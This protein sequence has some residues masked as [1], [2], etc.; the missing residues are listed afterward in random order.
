VVTDSQ[1]C[2]AMDL[3][4]I[5]SEDF[6]FQ[7]ARAL[8]DFK[9]LARKR[10][11]VLAK[12]HHPDCTDQHERVELFRAAAQIVSDIETTEYVPAPTVIRRKR[13]YSF[14]VTT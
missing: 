5:G 4:G 13:R 3:L 7:S 9:A 1:L 6:V 11:R 8:E 12:T 10:L 2:I 14:T